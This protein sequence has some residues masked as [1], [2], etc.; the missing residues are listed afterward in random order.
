MLT[1]SGNSTTNALGIVLSAIGVWTCLRGKLELRIW[2]SYLSALFIAIGSMIGHGT[3]LYEL[4]LLDELPMIYWAGMGAYIALEIKTNR[5]HGIWLPILL[6]AYCT[7]VTIACIVIRDPVFH[8]QAFGILTAVMVLRSVPW[9]FGNKPAENR[10]RRIL[11]I[12]AVGLLA[13]AFFLWNLDNH[14]CHHLSDWRT[15]LGYV[16]PL[17]QLHAWWHI[18][19]SVSLHFGCTLGSYVRCREIG[20][21]CSIQWWGRVLPVMIAEPLNK[22]D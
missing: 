9:L 5:R 7:V 19:V 1:C 22:R 13:L 18:L 8:E 16:A 11:Y 21:K 10:I 20:Q 14:F 6:I 15:D 17:T 3:L 12:T 2:L 4:Q